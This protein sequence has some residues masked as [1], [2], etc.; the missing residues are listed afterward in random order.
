MTN[1]KILFD[2]Y[3]FAKSSFHITAGAYLGSQ[4]I[5]TIY[6]KED[7]VLKEVSNYNKTS[8]AEPIG[9]KIG[10]YLLTPDDNGNVK[11]SVKTKSFRPYVGF[12]F[13]RAVPQEHRFALGVDCGVMFWGSPEFYHGENKLQKENLDGGGGFAKT[14]SKLSVWPCV[15][16]KLVGRLF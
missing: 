11:G 12:G 9:A 2:A 8:G 15:N 16:I 7:G 14:M 6:N 4:E 10:D 5:V 1:G 3:P 13:G